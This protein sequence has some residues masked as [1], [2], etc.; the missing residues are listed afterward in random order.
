MPRPPLAPRLAALKPWWPHLSPYA[1][2]VVTDYV[3]GLAPEDIANAQRTTKRAVEVAAS[4]ALVRLR[5]L[6]FKYRTGAGAM[7]LASNDQGVGAP[8]VEAAKAAPAGQEEGAEPR[9]AGV[10]QESSGPPPPTERRKIGRRGRGCVCQNGRGWRWQLRENTRISVYSPTYPTREL[11]EAAR[12]SYFADRPFPDPPPAGPQRCSAC[13]GTGHNRRHCPTRIGS[14]DL[15]PFVKQNV[16]C[17]AD[18]DLSSGATLVPTP[19]PVVLEPLPDTTP[20]A[21]AL[22]RARAKLARRA[23]NGW[24]G[25]PLSSTAAPR[26]RLTRDER[27]TG[28]EIDYPDD[29]KRPISRHECADMPRPCPFVS[30]SHHLYLDVNPT[31]GA[32]KFNFPH[33]EVWEMKETCSLDVADRGGITLEEVGAILNLTRERIRQVEVRGLEKIKDANGN[34]LGLSPEAGEGYSSHGR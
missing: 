16:G 5:G 33:L 30:C 18:L 17:K 14:P 27:R 15:G 31:T 2:Q 12:D 22:E 7:S 32:L 1:R 8:L 4:T 9:P 34:E 23:V 19:T 21:P 10:T 6:E 24:S 3:A 29:V 28:E 13:D 11:A 20:T 25:R 26:D